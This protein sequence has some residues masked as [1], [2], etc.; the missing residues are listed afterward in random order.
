MYRV[1]SPRVLDVE[2]T[3]SVLIDES[4]KW[5][6]ERVRSLFLKDEADVIVNIPL[7]SFPRRD[8]VLWHFDKHEIFSVKS[9]YKVAL[10]LREGGKASCSRGPLPLW[11]SLWRLKLPNKIKV[12]Y[13]KACLEA[14]PTKALLFSR[15][16]VV[17]SMCSL[18]DAG[19]ETV[20]HIL[21]DCPSVSLLR[22]SSPAFGLLK[23]RR[24]RDF[25][26]RLSWLFDVGDAGLIMHESGNN[27]KFFLFL[28]RYKY[29]INNY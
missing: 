20:D 2:A 1:L 27:E 21:W 19:F 7:C 28:K 12:F 6:V 17:S 8:S 9:A 24:F 22:K 16:I 18:C 11:K 10:S 15:G 23:G 13:W 5:D 14:L 4:G 25:K 29:N 26:D 3:V